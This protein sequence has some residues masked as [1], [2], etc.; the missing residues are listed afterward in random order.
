M[1]C[2]LKKPQP[3]TLMLLSISLA[4]VITVLIANY[5]TP[6][7]TAALWWLLGGSFVFFVLGLVLS[8]GGKNNDYVPW[9]SV[10]IFLN[11]EVFAITLSIIASAELGAVLAGKMFILSFFLLILYI[12]TF[13]QRIRL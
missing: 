5:K 11:S 8:M 9:G 7:T 6:I 13:F 12:L 10:A 4:F 1:I 3:M 2:S